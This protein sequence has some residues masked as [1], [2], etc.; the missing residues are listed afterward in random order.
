MDI[1]LIGGLWLDKSAWQQVVAELAGLGHRAVPVDGSTAASLDEQVAAVVAAVD[2]AN[3]KPLVVGH[4]AA[5]TL[6]WLA[7]DARPTQVSKVALIG[8]FPGSD[9][10]L[11]ADFFEMKD[12]AMAFPGWGP[13]EED[14]SAADLDADARRQFEAAAVPVPEGLARGVVRL[15]DERRYDVPVAAVCPEFSVAQAREW[16]AD[17]QVPELGKAKHL[18]LVDVD[19]GHWPMLTKPVE[20]ARILADLAEAA[21]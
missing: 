2:E 14:G 5:C 13:F 18:E 9:G 4:S 15:G 16:I 21:Q 17:G 10:E 1:L 3:G 20:L 7:A 6:A 11:Y 12:G 19:S 8:G